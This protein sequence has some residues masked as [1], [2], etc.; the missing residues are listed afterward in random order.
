MKDKIQA[1]LKELYS[2]T[3]KDNFLAIE[4]DYAKSIVLPYDDG[5]KFLACLKNAEMYSHSYNQPKTITHFDHDRFKTSVLSRKEYE[6]MKIAAMLGVTV[7]ELNAK[8]EP[9]T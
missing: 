9:V 6:D 7:E 1:A 8:P 5:L 2:K 3:P 4:V